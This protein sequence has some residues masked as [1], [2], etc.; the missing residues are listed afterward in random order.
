MDPI[1]RLGVCV[2]CRNHPWCPWNCIIRTAK[3]GKFLKEIHFPKHD[4]WYPCYISREKKLPCRERK[5]Y[6]LDTIWTFFRLDML[7]PWKV[8][9]W[10][11]RRSV[12]TCK[13]TI[14]ACIWW[15]WYAYLNSRSKPC[16]DVNMGVSL[17]GGFSPKSLI[18]IGFSIMF[19]IHFGVPL[20]LETPI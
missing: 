7:I 10:R 3:I 14:Q 6:I 12:G 18:L 9:S 13:L 5:H 17:N 8:N 1:I 2:F 16:W 11:K 19:T 4:C 15:Q 20:F